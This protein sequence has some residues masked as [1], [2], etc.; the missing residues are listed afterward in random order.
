MPRASF[1]SSSR[2]RFDPYERSGNSE[3]GGIFIDLQSTGVPNV[4]NSADFTVQLQRF[5]LSE[6][7]NWKCCVER[8]VGWNAV[9]NV[10]AA[11]GN[12]QLRYYKSLADYNGSLNERVLTAP[13][14]NYTF[15]ELWAVFEEQMTNGIG[16]A[17]NDY[18][19][20]GSIKVPWFK[21]E[22]NYNTQKIDIVFYNPPDQVHV[23][24]LADSQFYG[25]L[26]SQSPF[27]ANASAANLADVTNG[28]NSY[29]LEIPNLVNNSF[30]NALQASF[31]YG[32]TPQIPPGSS[33]DIYPTHRN[34]FDVKGS[35]VIKELTVRLTD[36]NGGQLIMA[37]GNANPF[38][39]RL[40]FLPYP[41]LNKTMNEQV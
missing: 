1:E 25:I 32:F 28:V 14:G 17:G 20:D 18:T 6:D 13:D 11:I 39:V 38:Q 7:Y 2:V 12:H 10:T 5:R 23:V 3:P 37:G 40:Q 19:L 21:L 33:F 26:A 22:P 35:G 27:T 29:M 31:L 16:I 30:S 15:E 34:W 36:Q 24:F 9:H 41:K 4:T 8:L